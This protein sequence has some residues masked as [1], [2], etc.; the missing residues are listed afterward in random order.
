MWIVFKYKKKE[1]NFLKNDFTK[2]L[3][4]LPIIFRPKIRYQKFIRNKIK[5][6]EKDILDDYLIC[7]HRKFSNTKMLEI[8][9]NSR[10]LKYFLID[11]Q[12]NQ[13]EIID[14]INLCKNNQGSDGYIKQSFFDFSNITKGMFL[15]GP[16]ANIVFDVIE[17]QKNKLKILIGNATTVIK[18]NSE[19]LYRSI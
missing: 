18:K 2:K 8:L 6:F 15:N 17:N 19:Y 4:E 3:G 5:F 7:F 10:G 14:F 13:K 1:L 16:F 11:S 12:I 9:K